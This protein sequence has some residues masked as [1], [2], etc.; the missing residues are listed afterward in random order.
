[1]TRDIFTAIVEN[2]ESGKPFVLA[3]IIRAAGHTPRDAGARMLVYADGSIE[4]T[5]GGGNFEKLVIDDCL[6]LLDDDSYHLMKSYK[7]EESGDD[8]TGMLCGGEVDVF[9]ETFAKPDSLIIFGGGHI[10]RALTEVAS[11]LGFK[12]TVVD[13]RPEIIELYTPPVR[14]VLTDEHY[15][16]N[17]PEIDKNSYVVIVTHGHKHD[18]E[19][20]VKV[21]NLDF[22]YLG[23]IGSHK[24]IAKTYESLS[25]E[26]IDKMLLDKIHAPIGLD[27][28]AEG[29][30]EIAVSIAAELIA[31]RRKYW[32]K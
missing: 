31:V 9:M 25:A 15:N 26:G 20:L 21:I 10:C 14:T 27:I 16:D 24:K 28:G 18:R 4:G 22:A 32:K 5:I 1:M 11:D 29:P 19:I 12:I 23:M 7:F 30:R 2:Q 17:F 8:S 3:T 6:R 13:S